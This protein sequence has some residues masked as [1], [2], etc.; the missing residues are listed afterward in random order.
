[1]LRPAV[2]TIGGPAQAVELLA[3]IHPRH[4]SSHA[5]DYAPSL[6][7]HPRPRLPP[8]RLAERLPDRRP[9]PLRLVVPH[10]PELLGEVDRIKHGQRRP[11]PDAGV[12]HPLRLLEQLL[13]GA[14]GVS[15]GAAAR[16]VDRN[17]CHAALAV[18]AR[19]LPQL[20]PAPAGQAYPV[21]EGWPPQ[22]SHEQ[23]PASTSMMHQS[24]YPWLAANALLHTAS[25]Q[26]FGCVWERPH[27]CPGLATPRRRRSLAAASTSP[28][29]GCGCGWN[30]TWPARTWPVENSRT[31]GG[32]F[33]G[34]GLW[35]RDGVESDEFS[36]QG[37]SIQ[38]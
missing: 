34:R 28:R 18:E 5:E 24:T 9:A 8:I 13:P 4:R 20:V 37:S 22:P 36:T 25:V 2:V 14:H 29:P 38:A 1:M 7:E 27:D 31:R 23:S 30:G 33:C 16:L 10:H 3:Q 32:I 11:L 26:A 35:L 17:P 19:R 21:L 15:V 12:A 6:L